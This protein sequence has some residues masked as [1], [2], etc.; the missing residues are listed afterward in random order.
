MN[1]ALEL[2]T[3]QPNQCLIWYI[4]PYFIQWLPASCFSVSCLMV[5]MRS[6]SLLGSLGNPIWSLPSVER[7]RTLYRT[8]LKGKIPQFT[9]LELSSII[10]HCCDLLI[11]AV[12]GLGDKVRVNSLQVRKCFKTPM[13]IL[14]QPT[15]GD[16]TNLLFNCNAGPANDWVNSQHWVEWLIFA[17]INGEFESPS[18]EML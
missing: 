9:S 1:L 16:Q 3:T 18:K 4:S 17:I 7:T 6:F 8:N 5:C 12:I 13:V 15:H 11:G 2:M 10:W 14:Q